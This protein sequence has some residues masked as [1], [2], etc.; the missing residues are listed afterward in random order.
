MISRACAWARRL[1]HTGRMRIKLG[2][3]AMAAASLLASGCQIYF[4]DHGDDDDQRVGRAA[5]G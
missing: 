4:G 1:L 2:L 5:H 3:L